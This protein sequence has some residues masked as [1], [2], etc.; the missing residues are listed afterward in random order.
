V[1]S[2]LSAN[3][4][5]LQLDDIEIPEIGFFDGAEDDTGGWDAKGFIRSSNFVPVEWIIWLIKLTQPTQVEKIELD[6]NQST[7]FEIEGF[8][9][10]FPFA[11]LVISPTATTTTLDLSY[12]L[13]FGD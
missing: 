8:G 9:E 5:G 1:I 4:D 2:D 10:E 11:A 3:R 7:E 12:E 13:I 6:S